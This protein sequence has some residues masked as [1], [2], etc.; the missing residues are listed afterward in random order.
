MRDLG[1]LKS[2]LEKCAFKEVM[3]SEISSSSYIESTQDCTA[4]VSNYQTEPDV[5][6]LEVLFNDLFCDSEDTILCSG[7]DEPLY[8]PAS[9]TGS[10]CKIHSTKDYFRSALH[11]ISHWCIAGNERRLLED[12]GY[13]YEPDGRTAEQQRL[14][15]KVEI[16]P[17]AME[18][19]FTE[20]CRVKF[21][22]SVDNVTNPDAGASDQFIADVVDQAQ[23]YLKFGLPSRAKVFC[24]CLMNHF[25]TSLNP[26][27]FTVSR[28]K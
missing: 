26:R 13:W 25:E 21:R 20:A 16:K 28:L 4:S 8:Q 27:D 22:L 7:A 17:Q 19:I 18:W 1:L 23:R 5:S 9:H 6:I 12:F 3:M 24:E 11:E 14:F 10:H 15:E 2:L